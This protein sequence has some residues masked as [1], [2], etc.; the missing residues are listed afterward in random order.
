[1]TKTK[2]TIKTNDKVEVT[3]EQARAIDEGMMFY[4]K[5]ADAEPERVNALSKGDKKEFARLQFVGKQ[6]GINMGVTYPWTGLFEPLNSLHAYDLNK[7][8]LKGY[9]VKEDAEL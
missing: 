6:L 3:W 7:A 5:M 9:I 8:I 1:M 2:I 4:L